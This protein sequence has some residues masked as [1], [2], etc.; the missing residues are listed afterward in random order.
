MEYTLGAQRASH[1]AISGRRAT[2][3]LWVRYHSIYGSVVHDSV[4][5]GVSHYTMSCKIFSVFSSAETPRIISNAAAAT[6]PKDK[7][8]RHPNERIC[9]HPKGSKYP[10]DIGVVQNTSLSGIRTIRV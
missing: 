4:L 3:T 7:L 8:R 10:N 9:Y 5:C 1:V 2:W 6:P